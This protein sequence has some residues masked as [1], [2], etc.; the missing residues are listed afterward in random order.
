MKINGRTLE[1]DEDT[2]TYLVDGIIVPSVTQLLSKKFPNK[3]SNIPPDVL[4][5]A[6]ERGTAIHKSIEDYCR[7]IGDET[8]RCVKNYCWLSKMF[9]FQ[10]VENELPIILDFG[11]KTYA[12]R[13]DMILKVNDV[14]A[15]A[16]IKTTAALDKEYLGLQLNLYRLGVEQSYDYKIDKLYGIHLREDTRKFVE[17]PIK[18]TKWLEESLILP[19]TE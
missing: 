11:G 2:H 4:R 10:A 16:D 12:G 9:R 8:D 7:G 18:E 19:E 6:A 1:F 5:R 14:Y 13:L 15:V 3:Y 17:I